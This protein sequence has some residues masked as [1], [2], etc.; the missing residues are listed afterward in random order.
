MELERWEI[1]LKTL[2]CGSLTAAAEA[3]GYTLSGVSRSIAALE[4]ET[5][6]LLLHREKKGVTAT[7]GCR[8]LLPAV[9]ELLFA[10]ER[11]E[12]TAA[13]VRGGVCGTIRIGTA[14]RPY[15]RWIMHV[16]SEFR[17]QYPEVQFRIFTGTSTEFAGKI[18]EHELDFGL[19]SRREGIAS[20][21]PFC[22]DPL[23]ALVPEHHPLAERE[24]VPI[25]EFTKEPYIDTCPGMDTDNARF[26]RQEKLEPN[27]Q[28]TTIDIQA[29]YAMVD[30]GLG[31]S[32][33]NH[34]N[35]VQ[36]YPGVCQLPLEPEY[37][38]EIGLAY[39]KRLSPAA[40]RFLEFVKK[41]IPKN[42]S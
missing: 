41:R 42:E 38:V 22:E 31:I 39:G 30:A 23:T 8:Q 17:E 33:N 11:L 27:T 12:Q 2:E 5:G 15:Y 13:S 10:A 29:S 7:D 25:T 36:G 18:Q 21:I 19:I 1:L 32:M 34:I 28:F 14:Y 24:K 4:K 3:T 9:R 20:W 37:L 6:I 40:E 16:T 35:S 26:F